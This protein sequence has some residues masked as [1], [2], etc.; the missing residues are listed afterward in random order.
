MQAVKM[1]NDEYRKVLSQKMSEIMTLK[2]E[3]ETST[4]NY[5]YR[6]KELE[7]EIAQEQRRGQGLQTENEQLLKNLTSEKTHSVSIDR[8]L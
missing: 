3:L 5:Q 2:R 4:K 6:I 8:D 1:A 7:F